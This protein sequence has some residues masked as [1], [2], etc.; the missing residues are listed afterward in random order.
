[1]GCG[2][3]RTFLFRVLCRGIGLTGFASVAGVGPTS[4]LADGFREEP[5]TGKFACLCLLATPTACSSFVGSCAGQ[6]SFLFCENKEQVLPS[7]WFSS[8]INHN[9]TCQPLSSAGTTAGSA[10]AVRQLAA[11]PPAG[12]WLEAIPHVPV[13]V[14]KVTLTTS[15]PQQ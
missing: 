8:S 7:C 14:E 2:F 13:R 5:E 4:V 1:M 3:A 15:N 6:F 10:V 11:P 9:L 12:S